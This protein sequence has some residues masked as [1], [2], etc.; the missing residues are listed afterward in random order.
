MYKKLEQYVPKEIIKY[1]E[2]MK[3]YSTFGIG[4]KVSAII[5]PRN[6]RELIFSISA[7]EKLRFKFQ[8][9][10]NASNILFNSKSSRRVIITTRNMVDQIALHQTKVLVSAGKNINE[11][12]LWCKDRGLSGLEGLYGIPA[13]VGGM[14]MMNAG[15]FGCQIYDKLKSIEV[16]HNGKCLILDASKVE[17]GH[18]YTKLLKS[19]MI[20]LSAEFCLERLASS[21]I[22]SKIKEVI[23]KRKEKQPQG[24][25]A[26]SVFTAL[27]DGTP[28]GKIIDDAGL[29]GLRVGGAVVS[30]KHANFII[31]DKN[32]TSQD[33]KILSKKIIESVYEKYKVILKREIEYIGERDAYYR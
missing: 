1:N 31:N 32:A 28:A 20:I 26:G 21:V 22:A 29:K 6:K 3:N 15:A 27:K 5:F 4:G 17:I 14:V 8:V 2:E 18:H 25:S 11:L 9:V 13:T 19:K 24:K 33:V 23:T 10:G 7:C 12:I 16:Y 30:L